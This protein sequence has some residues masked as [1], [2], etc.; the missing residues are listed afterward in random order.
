VAQVE[1]GTPSS[2]TAL[3]TKAGWDDVTGMGVPNARAFADF[4]RSAKVK[5]E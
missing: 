4:F 2:P 3:S 1:G 5:P